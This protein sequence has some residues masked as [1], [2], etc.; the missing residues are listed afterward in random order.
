[1]QRNIVWRALGH[2]VMLELY[3]ALVMCMMPW[4]GSVLPG[5]DASLIGGLV[6]VTIFVFS[7]AVAAILV[8][9]RPV[10]LYINGEKKAAIQ[11]LATTLGWLLALLI[12][13]VAGY[14]LFAR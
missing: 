13:T 3:I 14:L 6:F 10:M 5:D 11:F 12:L 8:F 2:A 4:L 1:M 9:G 7:A